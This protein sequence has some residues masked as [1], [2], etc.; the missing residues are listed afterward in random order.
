MLKL[1]PP[2]FWFER[3]WKSFLL[4]PVAAVFQLIAAIRKF[5]FRKIYRP[6]RFNVPIIV[7]GN[8]TVGGTGKTPLVIWLAEFLKNN[9]YK[10]GIVSRGY[11]GKAS[12]PQVVTW[13]SDPLEVGDEAIVI[14]RRTNCPMVIG[15]K[16]VAAVKKLLHESDC[17]VVISD[18]GL[19]HYALWRDLEIIVLDSVR[20]FGNG[21]CLP[22]GPLRES[23]IFLQHIDFKRNNFNIFFQDSGYQMQYNPGKFTN[24]NLPRITK[25]YAEFLGQKVHAVAGIG[26]PEKFFNLLQTLGLEIIKHPFP[27][28]YDFH[29][30]DFP[31]ANELIIM[32]EKDAVKCEKFANNNFWFLPITAQLNEDFG[33]K[34][35][36]NLKHNS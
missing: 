3:N 9:G 16:R 20:G 8:V 11:S 29:S 2:H 1:K 7:V 15:K 25:D 13:S 28:H 10:P 27:D 12:K 32:T 14:A 36:Y 4:L 19:Q 31:F 18:D 30:M 22:A 17:D 24:V 21:F 35:L 23:V 26:N 34:L 5:Y 6:F 33:S